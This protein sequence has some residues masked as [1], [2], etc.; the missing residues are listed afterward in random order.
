M[1][2]TD[3]ASARREDLVVA[4][5]ARLLGEQLGVGQP[6]DLA[7]LAGLED[8]GA[9]DQRPGAGA[10]AGLVDAGDELH[11]DPAQGALVAVEPGV[12]PDG[13]SGRR[14]TGS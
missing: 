3:Q 7:A 8:R 2:T 13:G 14:L 4:A 5:L 6:G 1:T 10:T 11:A 12:A 9:G